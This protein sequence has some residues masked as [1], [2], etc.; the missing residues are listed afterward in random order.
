MK[1]LI[2]LLLCLLLLAGCAAAYDGPTREEPRL[3]EYQV[4]HYSFF[5][6][7]VWE[8][9]STYAYDI[10]GNQVQIMEYD[11]GELS[12]VTKLR[13]DDRGNEISETLWDHSGWFPYIKRR[14]KQT[15]DDQNRPLTHTIYDMWGRKVGQSTYTYDDEA[16]TTTWSNGEGDHVVY[17]YGADGRH[18]RSVSDT[19]GGSYETVYEY[20][21]RG[22]RTG[23]TEWKDGAIFSR[24]EAGY[25]DQNRQIWFKRYD[26]NNDLTSQAAYVY[27]D[28]AHT[29]S[30][31]KPGGG[32]RIEYY[33]E[34]GRPALIEDYN[35]DGE[36][37]M[38]QMYT[39]RD[40][41]VPMKGEE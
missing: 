16:H 1:K 22:N 24:Y 23:F 21:E 20:D 25:D 32:K 3:T 38:V 7:E 17:Y 8:D 9:R 26:E 31:D 15:Y 36:L 41:R 2:I 27:D 39:Y 35:E 33:H 18:L 10:Y 37:S 14:I 30:Y 5:S 40:I 19:L 29:M 4:R 28:E 34:D 6:D 13:Y 12:C 11:D